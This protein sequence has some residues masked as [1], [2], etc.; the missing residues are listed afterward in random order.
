ME[1]VNA[2]IHHG[3]PAATPG[4]LPFPF[5]CWLLVGREGLEKKMMQPAT[6]SLVFRDCCR[7][8]LRHPLLATSILRV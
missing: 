7:D 5:S 8:S 2:G 1:K 6:L 3:D 4:A